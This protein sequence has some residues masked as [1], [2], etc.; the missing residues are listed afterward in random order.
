M[1]VTLFDD[2]KS[3][4]TPFAHEPPKKGKRKAKMI[5]HSKLT[6]LINGD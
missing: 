1:K 6:Y 4:V 2:L 5:A 3:I